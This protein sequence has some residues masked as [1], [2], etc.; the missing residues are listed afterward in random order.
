MRAY[1][2]TESNYSTATND[3]LCSF[4]LICTV[5]AYPYAIQSVHLMLI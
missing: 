1:T 4:T 3:L 5:N 2:V